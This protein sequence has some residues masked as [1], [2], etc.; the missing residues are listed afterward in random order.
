M[1]RMPRSRAIMKKPKSKV[2][3]RIGPRWHVISEYRKCRG[4]LDRVAYRTGQRHNFVKKWVKRFKTTGTV[5]DKPRS[6]RPR[7]LTEQQTKLLSATVEQ[8]KSVPEAVAQLRKEGSI[9]KRVSTRTA[10]RAVAAYCNFKTPVPQPFLTAEAK[11]Q[12]A[13]FSAGRYRVGNLVPI[14]SSIFQMWGYQPRR[15][16][17]VRKGTTPLQ[18]RPIRSQKLHVYAGICKHGKT[19]LVYATG[20]TGLPKRYHKAGGKGPYRGVCAEEFQDIM[21]KQLYPQAQAIMRRAGEPKPVFLMDG[22]TPHTAASTINFLKA[23]RIRF[24]RNWPPNSPDL[25]PIENLWAWL[26]REVAAELPSSFADFTATLEAAWD[27]VPDSM[28]RK[29]MRSFHKRLRK[30]VEC[31]GGHTGY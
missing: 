22:A 1:L 14:D 6:G 8:D 7:S 16:R 25:N 20:T 2:T 3:A 26:K 4:D 10:C 18:P 24:L 5:Y 13:V 29:L 27:R 15:G 31:G 21:A 12:R 11:Q 17:W 28:L 19:K 9:P 30:C 23:K